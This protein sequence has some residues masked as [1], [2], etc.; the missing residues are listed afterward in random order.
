MV[1]RT[2]LVEVIGSDPRGPGGLVLRHAAVI[3]EVVHR[4]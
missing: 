4:L 3:D 1:E 2:G